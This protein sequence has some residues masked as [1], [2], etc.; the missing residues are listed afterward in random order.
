LD[1]SITFTARFDH[2]WRVFGGRI[3]WGY[4]PWLNL[5]ASMPPSEWY[6]QGM[7][8]NWPPGERWWTYEFGSDVFQDKFG[9]AEEGYLSA[10]GDLYSIHWVLQASG[11]TLRNDIFRGIGQEIG[12]T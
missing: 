7:R 6:T 8:P 1:V 3:G 12:S 11:F 10:S 2:V 5:P 9:D 4:Q